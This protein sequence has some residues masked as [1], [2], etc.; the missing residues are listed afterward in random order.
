MT[1]WLVLGGT[2]TIARTFARM[3]ADRG[4]GILLAGRDQADLASTAADCAARGAPIAEA[5]AFDA[6]D[7]KS[8]DAL[9]TRAEALDG[10]LSVAVF[11]GS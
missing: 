7:S 9:V 3:V 5:L 11:V 6:R 2:S 1:T 4:E 8:F 10:A